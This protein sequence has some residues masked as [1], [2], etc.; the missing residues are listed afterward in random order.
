MAKTSVVK[1][2]RADLVL[3]ALNDAVVL[4]SVALNA[5]HN[6][7]SIDLHVVLHSDGG[8]TVEMRPMTRSGVY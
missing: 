2:S 5:A 3:A 7:R 4:Q 6:V 1:T 8:I